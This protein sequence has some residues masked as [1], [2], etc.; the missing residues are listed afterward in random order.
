MAPPPLGGGVLHS[1]FFAAPKKNEPK[2]RGPRAGKELGLWPQTAFPEAGDTENGIF[3]IRKVQRIHAHKA[4]RRIRATTSNSF[5]RGG[6]HKKRHLHNPQGTK[7]TCTQ[8]REKDPAYAFWLLFPGQETLAEGLLYIVISSIHYIKGQQASLP[9]VVNLSVSPALF[10]LT[11][12][13]ECSTREKLS[14][15]IGRVLFPL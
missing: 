13:K 11:G 6:R 9:G 15:A 12:G 5:S 2:R 14:E 10:C 3:T 4:G 7:D 1:F 8:G